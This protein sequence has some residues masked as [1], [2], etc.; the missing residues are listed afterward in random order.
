M[1]EVIS[2]YIPPSFYEVSFITICYIMTI[3]HS[4]FRLG[5]LFVLV[6]WQHD[7][8][9][10]HVRHFDMGSSQVTSSDW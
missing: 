7:I 4:I 10:L 9:A 2:T 1:A 3:T 5:V 8:L 6:H